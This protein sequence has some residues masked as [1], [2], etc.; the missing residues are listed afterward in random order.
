MKNGTSFLQGGPWSQAHPIC[1][2]LDCRGE[3]ASANV[4]TETMHLD[5]QR[6]T[7]QKTNA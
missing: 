3:Y 2:L 5:V 6:R 1:G 7:L 4:H